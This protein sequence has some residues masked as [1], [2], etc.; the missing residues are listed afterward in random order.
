MCTSKNQALKD[1]VHFESGNYKE[2]TKSV[3][4]LVVAESHIVTHGTY[5]KH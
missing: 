3:D 4:K 1:V 2:C 5:A